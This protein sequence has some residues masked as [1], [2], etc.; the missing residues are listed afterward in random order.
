[1]GR[2][3]SEGH[4]IPE[5]LLVTRVV[6]LVGDEK[7]RNTELSHPLDCLVVFLGDA[8]RSVDDEQ[9]DVG[10]AHRLLGLL[11]D[12]VVH[13]G[14]LGHPTTGVDQQEVTT[15][16]FGLDLFPIAGDA[17][18]LLDDGLPPPEDPVHQGGL[19]DIRT[20]DDHHRWQSGRNRRHDVTRAFFGARPRASRSAMP[21][22]RMISTGRGR[23]STDVP[24]RNTPPE[25]QTSGRR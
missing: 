24:S 10:L 5:A 1:M 2:A 20:A 21:S 11:A 23:S 12:L 4:E 14:A 3:E 18:T 9:H 16:P 25:R 6:D 22:V 15:L 7:H 8:D 19:A 17:R 13:G